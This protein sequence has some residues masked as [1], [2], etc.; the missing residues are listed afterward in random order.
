[1]LKVE[2]HPNVLPNFYQNRLPIFY[3]LKSITKFPLLKLVI[4]FSLPIFIY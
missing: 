3:L 4:D 2:F 1:M